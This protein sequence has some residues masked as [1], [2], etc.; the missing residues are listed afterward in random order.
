MSCTT[1]PL[2]TA[3]FSSQ[4]QSAWVYSAFTQHSRLDLKVSPA[5][6]APTESR[7]SRNELPACPL[8]AASAQRRGWKGLPGFTSLCQGSPWRPALESGLP[9]LDGADTAAQSERGV[10]GLQLQDFFL[11]Q[12]RGQGRCW[13]LGRCC[14]LSLGVASARDC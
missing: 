1:S 14:W 4:A 3:D 10:R 13:E 11:H 6:G 9:R 5:A 2:S 7:H 12:K 8:L